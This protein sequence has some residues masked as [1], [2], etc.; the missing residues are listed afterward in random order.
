MA[1]AAMTEHHVRDVMTF[2]AVTVMPDDTVKDALDLLVANDVAALP[3]VDE[4]NRCVGVI[5][6]SDLLGL[7]Q[8]RGE[9]LEAIHAAE[10]LSRELLIE[11]LAR[12]DFSDLVV[13]D[14]MSP[15]PIVIGPDAPLPEAARI[16]V[17]YGIHHLAVIENGHRFLGVL[18]ALDIVRALA[19]DQ[20]V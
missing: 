20:A 13:A 8:E 4:A 3:V 15:T 18:S 1:R 19:G 7:A 12:A 14:A 10:G 9:D 2:H 6:A 16:M 11:H 17:D 5:S